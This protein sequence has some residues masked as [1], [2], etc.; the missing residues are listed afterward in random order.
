MLVS[1]GECV[2]ERVTGR[3]GEQ[4]DRECVRE[5]VTGEK[6]DRETERQT[7]KDAGAASK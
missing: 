6:R 4:T 2:R 5:R 3:E 7:G 1:A